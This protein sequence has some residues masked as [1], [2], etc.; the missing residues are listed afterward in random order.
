MYG[1]M[2]S[3]YNTGNILP[4]LIVGDMLVAS[5]PWGCSMYIMSFGVAHV[6]SLSGMI[7]TDVL[8]QTVPPDCKS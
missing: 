2:F 3:N 7:L 4:V 8:I 1:Y 6:T 5:C